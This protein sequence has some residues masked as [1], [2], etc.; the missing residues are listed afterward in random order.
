ML[1]KVLLLLV[2]PA[3]VV[4]F[5]GDSLGVFGGKLANLFEKFPVFESKGIELY[6]FLFTLI[7]YGL[8]RLFQW[9]LKKYPT[10]W[11][12]AGVSIVWKLLGKLFGKSIL[13]YNQKTVDE[14]AYAKAVIEAKEHLL[15]HN[16]LFKI[17]LPK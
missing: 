15:K 5:A 8:T 3:V 10:K 7:G 9:V 6:S 2:I 12:T 13:F 16:P 4:V 17:E 14:V 1:K 11:T